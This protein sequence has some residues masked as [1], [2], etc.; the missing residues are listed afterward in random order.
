MNVF[1]ALTENNNFL[2][3]HYCEMSYIG[4]IIKLLKSE[5]DDSYDLHVL[6][7]GNNENIV[8]N[9]NIK[10]GIHIGNEIPY[11]ELNYDKL[12]IIFRFYHHN[13]CDLKK[14]YPINIGY[15]SSGNAD[16][17]FNNTKKLN[18]RGIDVFFIGQK[19]N[20]YDFYHKINKINQV[21]NYK[22]IFTNGFRQGMGI[23]E[24]VRELSDVKICLVPNGLSN[25]TFR[26]TEAFA[27]GCIVITN[28][29]INTWYYK[30]SPA[31]FINDWS[32]VTKDFI[33]KILNMDLN[34]L[35]EKN[36]NYYNNYLS[37]Q[38][39]FNYILNKIKQL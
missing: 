26:Y 9:G 14:V 35:Y 17:N 3:D 4:E 18:H 20:R 30:D 31:F 2:P 25:E 24:Y 27:S 10:I 39:N 32:E 37:P 22:I 1:T 5:L 8:T 11:N 13:K 19:N 34:G 38:A 12:D 33:N 21:E 36:I 15:N 29:N 7:E 23:D 16:I 28:I 6:Y